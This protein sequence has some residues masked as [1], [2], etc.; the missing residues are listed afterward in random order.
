MAGLRQDS[1]IQLRKPKAR[2]THNENP[3]S[4]DRSQQTN[5][6]Q[7]GN[8]YNNATIHNH[9]HGS[10]SNNARPP[11]SFNSER[12]S[13]FPGAS[14]PDG[15]L[16]VPIPLPT[17]PGSRGVQQVQEDLADSSETLPSAA[18]SE[19]D[20]VQGRIQAVDKGGRRR[21]SRQSK[22]I[23]GV[24]VALL[25]TAAVAIPLIATK[26]INKHSTSPTSVITSQ[27]TSTNAISW[28]STQNSSQSTS[29]ATL[30]TS[31]NNGLETQNALQ[32]STSR[33]PLSVT[34]STTPAVPASSCTM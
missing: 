12:P 32:T 26:V 28:I 23:W 20:N 8:I 24:F 30:N 22:I 34:A 5:A 7:V 17:P 10:L 4:S 3:K 31:T 27:N 29:P 6:N 16:T 1:P 18:P 14:D 21:S 2:A 15:S 11:G 25:V 13:P 9:H 33:T 19:S